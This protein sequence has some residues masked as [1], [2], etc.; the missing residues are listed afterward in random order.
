[1]TL[2]M[3]EYEIRQMYRL[4]KDKKEQ[5]KILADLNKCKPA[6]IRSLL[7]GYELPREKRNIP[8]ETKRKIAAEYL[9]GGISQHELANKYRITHTTVRNIIKNI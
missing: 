2:V 7:S 9:K 8:E 4:A 5:I 1:M 6:V 3:T